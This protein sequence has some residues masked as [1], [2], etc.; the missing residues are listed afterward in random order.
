[1][2]HQGHDGDVVGRW[3]VT[4]VGWRVVVD[5]CHHGLNVVE[6]VVLVVVVVCVVLVVG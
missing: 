2:H 3:V 6:G 1:M 5:V 4:L